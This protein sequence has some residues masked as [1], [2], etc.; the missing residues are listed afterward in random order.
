MVALLQPSWCV[1]FTHPIGSRPHLL[2]KSLFVR[3][4]PGN[5]TPPGVPDHRP[6]SL[7][8][9]SNIQYTWL[10]LCHLQGDMRRMDSS[11]VRSIL[12][13]GG[14]GDVGE[15]AAAITSAGAIMPVVRQRRA[16]P[17]RRDMRSGLDG[18]RQGSS[19]SRDGSPA[20]SASSSTAGST[21][22]ST[23]LDGARK[24]GG[25]VVEG[26]HMLLLKRGWGVEESR[27]RLVLQKLDYLQTLLVS[28]A[29]AGL[30]W[31]KGAALTE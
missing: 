30:R 4:L 3:G 10:L 24:E 11:L 8:D 17:S 14:V 1:I 13:A 29:V 12:R 23:V 15:A 9:W 19:S 21:T 22:D 28:E 5:W 25:Y 6:T 7:Q 20:S 2:I 26:S 16:S 27:G 31:V 18:A